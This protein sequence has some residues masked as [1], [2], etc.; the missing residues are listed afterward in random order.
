MRSLLIV[1]LLCAPALAEPPRGAFVEVA[2][3][4]VA[5][6]APTSRL[7]FLHRCPLAGCPI[8]AGTNDDARTNTSQIAQ[9]NTTIGAFTQS[10]DVWKK[11]LSCVRST[12]APFDVMVTDVDPGTTTP[13]YENVVGGTPGQLRDDIPNAGGV[14]PLSCVEV[15][16]GMSFTFDVYGNDPLT[17][18]WT[19]SQEIGHAFGLDHE[20]EA[21]DPMSYL[22]G[23]LPKR[24]QAVDA[25][26]GEG[27]PR[28]CKGCP[29]GTNMQNSYA[30]ILALF[31]PGVPTPPMVVVKSPTSGTTV[32]PHFV[33]RLTATDDVAVDH[34]ELLI[35][36]TTVAESHDTPYT[37]V[38]PD[39][40]ADGPHQ[41]EV[42][43]FDVQGTPGGV[44]LDI[45]M[46][47]PCTAASGC[48]GVDVCVA[49]V[50]L[51]GPDAAGGLGYDC[52]ADTECLS[53]V[54]TRESGKTFG[55]CTEVCDPA[56]DGVCPSGFA[57]LDAG[58]CWPSEAGGCCETGG[59]PT[60]PVMLT[61]GVVVLVLRRRR[62]R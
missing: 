6:H 37:I 18:C 28:A 34:V 45:V 23:N 12:F 58:V 54:C 7:I 13:H 56:V 4:T 21:N 53:R 57:C 27:Q 38:A 39:G 2:P 24:F 29:V 50:C 40:I 32:Q 31:G 25:P 41:M 26:C 35:D 36:G 11:L 22:G 33:T 55:H 3:T 60:G 59:S 48:T 8:I 10:D 1:A 5:P 17:L 49:G 47:P 42:R 16:N 30:K 51:P 15:P 61:F 14:A 19:A 52:S 62:G 43:A 44:M 46:G 9:Q 20:I